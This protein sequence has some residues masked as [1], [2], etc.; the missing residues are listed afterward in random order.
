[1]AEMEER[2]KKMEHN[3]EVHEKMKKGEQGLLGDTYVEHH[4]TRCGG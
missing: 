4:A 1:M 3:T 2:M